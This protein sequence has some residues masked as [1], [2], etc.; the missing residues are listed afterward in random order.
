MKRRRI[1]ASFLLIV[2]ALIWGSGYVVAEEVLRSE[3]HPFWMLAIRFLVGA[4]FIGII[5]HKKMRNPTF[6]TVKHSIIAG[7]ILFFALVFEVIGQKNTVVSNAAL[8]TS[9]NVVIVPYLV[10]LFTKKCPP[11]KTFM[12]SIISMI[13]V[14]LLSFSGFDHFSI[15]FGDILVLLGAFF[16]ALHI[17]WISLFCSDDSAEQLAFIQ[18]FVAGLCSVVMIVVFRK[19]ITIQQIKTQWSHILYL[20][21]FPTGLCY[22]LQSYAEK[23]IRATDT[24]IILS[25]EGI[26]G[27]ILSLVLGYEQYRLMIVIG[28]ALIMFSIYMVYADDKSEDSS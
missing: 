9:S 14:F 24:V 5:F 6:S 3:M 2:V 15:Y 27:T 12:F 1:I 23:S 7:V 11:I 20:A 26:F 8:I 28:A 18:L 4:L 19:T 16:F 17:V 21:V 25:A 10:W 22:F 13:G